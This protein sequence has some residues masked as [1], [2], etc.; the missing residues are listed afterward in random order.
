MTADLQKMQEIQGKSGFLERNETEASK[1]QKRTL[2][3]KSAD[4]PGQKVQGASRRLSK[5]LFGGL[6][7]LEEDHDA[8]DQIRTRIRKLAATDWW[9][10]QKDKAKEVLLHTGSINRLL[11]AASPMRTEVL[12]YA[13]GPY[14]VSKTVTDPKTGKMTNRI[15]DALMD[16]PFFWDSEHEQWES[17]D[18]QKAIVILPPTKELLRKYLEEERKT[19]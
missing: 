11:D 5:Y 7:V 16:E 1:E 13:Y 14:W 15:L 3:K 9:R 2:Q 18:K 12:L 4:L 17:M 19:R 10:R 6:Y 8:A